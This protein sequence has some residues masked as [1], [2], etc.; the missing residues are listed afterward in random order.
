MTLD[1][2]PAEM[3]GPV[4]P[5]QRVGAALRQAREDAG[6]SLRM[7]AKELG[8]NSHTTLS[9]FERGATMPT[10]EVVEA[11]ER[12]LKLPSGSLVSVLEEARIERHGDAWPKRRVHVPLQA[13]QSEGESADPAS[14]DGPAAAPF[15][16]AKPD[17]RRP[18]RRLLT[19]CAVALVLIAAA[20]LSLG[21]TLGRGKSTVAVPDGS[22]P[23]VTGCAK[24][25][26]D[27]DQS[28]S[29]DVFFP[30]QH[31]AGTLQ[32]R[33][34]TKC[35]TA[36]GRFVP[37]A[38]LGTSPPVTIEVDVHRPADNGA[39]LF[40]VTNDGQPA[41]GG[42]LHADHVCVYATVKLTRGATSSA[43]FSTTCVRV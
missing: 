33:T 14:T 41:Y 15:D 32:L 22:D 42:M 1:D 31:L 23:V 26:D 27:L 4:L 8:Y 35:G 20:G 38:A 34:S 13:V 40:H 9:G 21:L 12:V 30:A 28:T 5:E 18:S 25:A 2:A 36:W 24:K 29:M 10:D 17:R 3:P 6:V 37:T 43:S 19:V 7:M 11:Y 39:A 16:E